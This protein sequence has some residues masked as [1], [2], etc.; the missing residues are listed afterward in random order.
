MAISEVIKFGGTPDD[1][2]WKYPGEEFNA[3][4]QLI[5]DET[6]QALLVVN[7]QA[8]DLFGPGRHTLS[9]PNIPLVKKIINIPTDGISPFNCKIFYVSQVHQMDML[10]GTQGPITL[11]DPVFEVFLHVRVNGS[12][13][14]SAEDMRK[15]LLKLVGFRN[16]FRAP[17]MVQKFR[18][19]ISSHVKD[20][21][22]KIM[23]NGPMS[24]FIINAYLF[25]ISEVVKERIS[26]IFEEYGITVEYFNIETV[27]VPESDYQ[28]IKEARER[29]A[30]RIIE[31][32]T[33]QEERQ[34]IIAEKFASNEGTMGD[35]GGAMGGMMM[36]GALGG[37]LVEIAR[38][39]LSPDRI[40]EGNPPKD[41]TGA[42]NPMSTAGSGFDVGGFFRGTSNPAPAPATSEDTP[43]PP[44][45]PT[46]AARFCEMCG[47]P[48]SAGALFCSQCGA[49]QEPQMQCKNCG[50]KLEPGQLFCPMCGTPV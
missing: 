49:K 19:L 7:G 10:W 31:G 17:D 12:M 50:N 11:D 4:S 36:G 45:A 37:S 27:D 41:T 34:M 35:I 39:A 43:A 13:T 6:H 48:L 24:Y 42:H 5:V 16:S 2:V 33:W 28:A 15:F 3:T 29:R 46:G 18:G 26:A 21:I 25:D 44:T 23:I 32:Y 47:A 8:A 14:F 38:S 22:S 1:L 40:P 30:G 9:V 20:C